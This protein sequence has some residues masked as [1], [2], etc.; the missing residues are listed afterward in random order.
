MCG[1]AGAIGKFDS[2]LEKSV[3]AMNDAQI[4][5]GPDDVGVWDSGTFAGGM[6]CV[7]G[8]RRL[9]IVDLSPLGHQPMVDSETGCTISYNGEIYNF[10]SLREELEAVGHQFAS[11][12]DTEVLLRAWIEWGEDCLERLEGMFA[13][14]LW[15]PR[16]KA[17]FLARDRMGIKPAYYAF[18]D[19]GE[20]SGTESFLF[21]SELRALLA[22]GRIERRLDPVAFRTF[23]QNGFVV[24]PNTIVAGI[25]QLPAGSVM[26]VGLDG[27]V[28][29]LRRYWSLPEDASGSLE[30]EAAVEE[31]CARLESAVAQR[32]VSDVP[33]GIFLSGGI[34]SSAVAA[35]AQSSSDSPITTFNIRFDEARYDESV[36]AAAVAREIRSDHREVTLSEANF[37]DG[38]PDALA[39]LDQPTF[40]AVN[41]Y[42]VSRSVREAGLTVALAGTGGDELFG[43]YQSFRDL[44]RARRILRTFGFVPQRLREGAGDAFSWGFSGR[45]GS[46]PPQTRWGK[47]R[48]LISSDGSL[49]ALYQ[50]SSALFTKRFLDAL[51]AHGDDTGMIAGLPSV[52]AAELAEQV[53]GSPDL[54]GVSQLELTLFLGERLLRD[55]DAA[56]MAVSLEVRVPFVDHRLIEAVAALPEARRFQPIGKKALLR[57]L[58]TAGIDPKIFDR[59]KAGFELPF[60]VW[61]RNRLRTQVGETLLDADLC[62]R[63]GLNPVEVGNL[64]AAFCDGRPGIYWSRIWA[65]FVLMWW[66]REYDI[67]L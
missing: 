55:T 43:G 34:D 52:R 51:I 3:R 1:I 44:P 13:F 19:T 67:G 37:I 62:E 65:L 39:S 24:G 56:S 54:H 2:G 58:G 28:E 59:P 48:D 20:S 10:L 63:V 31:V 61:C 30:T 11:R 36:H 15:D 18:A 66:S 41:T 7:L 33:L 8:H 27:R 42:F 16:R 17:I 6:G 64:W 50:T 32:L 23:V 22:T 4:H 53:R 35:L 5:R 26:R 38:L 49:L 25:Q 9:S 12:C 29:K 46:V 40:D 21:A 45:G 14:A 60:D 57:Q 47:L